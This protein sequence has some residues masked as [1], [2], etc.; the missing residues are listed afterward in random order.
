MQRIYS[1]ALYTLNE[2][3]PFARNRI[4]FNQIP[5]YAAGFTFIFLIDYWMGL[6]V[7][8]Q[9]HQVA[10]RPICFLLL[11]PVKITTKLTR[12]SKSIV[13]NTFLSVYF[14]IFINLWTVRALRDSLLMHL[15]AHRITRCSRSYSDFIVLLVFNT[16]VIVLRVIHICR[17]INA[18]IAQHFIILAIFWFTTT[19]CH[20][21]NVF[22]A[23][24]SSVWIMWWRYAHCFNCV[25]VVT[26]CAEA[27]RLLFYAHL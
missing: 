24:R 1:T 7:S 21:V 20:F 14:I 9:L 5:R 25:W 13:L 18:Y 19:Q 16:L 23:N 22:K 15:I 2:S 27:Y 17:R 6:R 26:P 4:N 12:T 3:R 11:L 8:K 10:I